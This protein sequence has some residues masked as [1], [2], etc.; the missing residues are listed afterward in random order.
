MTNR[1][2]DG[3]NYAESTIASDGRTTLPKSV[4]ESLGI[5]PGDRI[6]YFILDNNEVRLLP[7]RPFSRLFGV[8][9]HDGPPPTIE[10]ME[11]AVADGA[12]RVSP[13]G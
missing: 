6:R 3:E 10:D 5:G 8:L 9:R 12:A 4:R 11:R 1:K 2:G 13:T 7:V